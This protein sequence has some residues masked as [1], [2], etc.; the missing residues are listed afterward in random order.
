MRTFVSEEKTL[1]VRIVIA[2]VL[3]GFGWTSVAQ[4]QTPS[5]EAVLESME[6][7]RTIDV[8]FVRRAC[9]GSAEAFLEGQSAD[10]IAVVDEAAE[11]DIA[12]SEPV[13]E[14]EEREKRRRFGLARRSERESVDDE[15]LVVTVTGIGTS[16][17]GFDQF[18]LSDG[19]LLVRFSGGYAF[20]EP[21]GLPATARLERRF[22]GSKWLTFDEFPGRSYKVRVLRAGD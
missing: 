14:T 3:A 16:G 18:R 10:E 19:S 2:L 8:D 11:P 7:C 6:T 15:E 4:A 9:L 21:S 5:R 20:R 12:Q 22:L 1:F 17:E 13:P